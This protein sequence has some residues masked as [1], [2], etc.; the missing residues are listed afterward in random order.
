M[1]SRNIANGKISKTILT[2][3]TD[4]IPS[5]NDT[6]VM[7]YH[8]TTR[9]SDG[10]VLDDNRNHSTPLEIIFGK[11]F[12]LEVWEECLKT[13][14][15]HEVARFTVS[16]DLLSCYPLVAKSLR[17]IAK[18]HDGTKCIE[19]HDHEQ[20][21]CCGMQSL[22]IKG[23]GYPDLDDFMKSPEDLEFELEVVQVL[24]SGSY[25]KDAWAMNSDEKVQNVPRLHEEGN[26]LYKKQKYVEASDRSVFACALV[27]GCGSVRE[28]E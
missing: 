9:L 4:P 10:S 8:K 28:W 15:L 27:F 6:K 7:F 12:K 22:L 16:A 26:R 20:H 11:Q 1:S 2:E 5:Q 19:E 23:L 3:G 25:E 14:Q 21:H 24:P 18:N 13:M 17:D